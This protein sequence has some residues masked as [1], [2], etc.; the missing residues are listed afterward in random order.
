MQLRL[1]GS[2]QNSINQINYLTKEWIQNIYNA[3]TKY[4]SFT[5]TQKK[6]KKKLKFI[7]FFLPWYTWNNKTKQKIY[8]KINNIWNRNNDVKHEEVTCT[9]TD[10]IF[11]LLVKFCCVKKSKGTDDSCS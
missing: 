10:A 4:T 6:K 3:Y 9:I 1:W 7:I 5:H 11:F 2:L 8:K